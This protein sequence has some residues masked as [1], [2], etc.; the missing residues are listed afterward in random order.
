[1][2]PASDVPRLDRAETYAETTHRIYGDRRAAP[3]ARELLLAVAYALFV[4]PGEPGRVLSTA[5][6]ALGRSSATG[7]PP[8]LAFDHAA[9]L[10]AA[11]DTGCE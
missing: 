3:P 11:R 5:A 2:S 9:I 8:Q 6:R 1:M 4:A 10:D 7:R